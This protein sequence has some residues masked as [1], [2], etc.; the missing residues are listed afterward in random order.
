VTK[1]DRK[2]RERE[3]RSKDIIDA[4]ESLF[5]SKG[6]DDVSMNDIAHE[7]EMARG[8]LYKYFKNKNDII[9]SIA[10]RASKIITEMFQKIDEKNQTGIEKIRTICLIY[11]DFY[12]QHKGYYEAYYHSGLFNNEGSENLEN[13]REI[14]TKNFQ[15]VINALNE[16]INDGTIRD[17]IDPIATTLIMLSMSNAVNNLIP[18][19]QMYM[20]D[21][22]LTQDLLFD[23]TLKMVL[24]SIK[25]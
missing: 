7:T 3:I 9:A 13:L 10:I 19:T 24:N 21:H 4:A 17:D 11:Y 1:A 8:T 23:S 20:D 5:F 22:G 2:E 14:R 15:M 12:K 18:V 16:G 6:Y 25:K